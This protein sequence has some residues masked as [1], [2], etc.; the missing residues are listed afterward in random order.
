MWFYASNA[1]N[2]FIFILKFLKTKSH[3]LCIIIAKKKTKKPLTCSHL[4]NNKTSFF[5][6]FNAPQI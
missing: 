1:A 2:I 3:M 6:Q 4:L 5:I